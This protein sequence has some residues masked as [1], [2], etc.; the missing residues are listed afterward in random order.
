MG[1]YEDKTKKNIKNHF[2]G[3]LG[4]FKKKNLKKKP[5]KTTQKKPVPSLH[6]TYTVYTHHNKQD[7]NFYDYCR[8]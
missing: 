3:V 5:K 1:F 2:L 6:I 8:I 4:F 7:M